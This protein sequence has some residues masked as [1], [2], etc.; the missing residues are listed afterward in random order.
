MARR[1]RRSSAA[2]R[3]RSSI[4]GVASIIFF[5]IVFFNTKERVV[6]PK[7][8]KTSVLK[9][10]KDLGDLVTNGPWL[11]LVATTITFILFVALRGNMTAHYFKYYVGS[12]TVTLPAVLSFLPKSAI[13]TQVWGWESLVSVFNTSNQILSL[14]RGRHAGAVRGADRGPQDGV[15]GPLRDRDRSTASFYVLKPDQLPLIF[16]INLLGSITGGPIIALLMTMYA[17]TADYGEWRKGRRATG[18]IFSASIFSQKQGWAIGAWVALALMNSVGFVANTAQ[19]ASSLHGLVLLMSLL[20]AGIGVVSMVILMFYPLHER[21]MARSRSSLRSV[22]QPTGPNR[23]SRPRIFCAGRP[24]CRSKGPR[25]PRRGARPMRR[26]NARR[27]L[28]WRPS[29]R[30]A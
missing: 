14:A 3:C 30:R 2:G 29:A 12:Q 19:T 27:G 24:R 25:R 4:Y 23:P 21:K 8:Q 22:A 20:P 7:A 1:P 26:H 16:G 10:G 6:P 17:D 5:L 13:G 28:R 18:L 9:G 11:I 15:H